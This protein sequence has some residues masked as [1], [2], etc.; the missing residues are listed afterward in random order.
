MG[1][2]WL[3]H[4]GS[5]RGMARA[6]LAEVGDPRSLIPASFC[7]HCASVCPYS[8]DRLDLQSMNSILLAFYVTSSVSICLV[9]RLS[10]GLFPYLDW[11]VNCFNNETGLGDVFLSAMGRIKTY[12]NGACGGKE[13]Y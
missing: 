11:L 1:G 8:I 4:Y 9:E 5:R 12:T 3:V 2:W 7:K 13:E 6:G 10:T